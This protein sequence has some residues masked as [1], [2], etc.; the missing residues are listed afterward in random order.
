M[1]N[2]VSKTVV[3]YKDCSFMCQITRQSK[4]TFVYDLQII[5][6]LIMS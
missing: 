2:V 4:Q 6:L 3:S 1:V 5:N